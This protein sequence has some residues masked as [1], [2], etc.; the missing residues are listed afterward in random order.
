MVKVMPELPPQ[1]PEP[2]VI[3]DK[4]QLPAPAPVISEK[5]LYEHATVAAVRVRVVPKALDATMR[6]FPPEAPFIV[7]VP[8]QV[9]FPAR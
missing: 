6:R 8:V 9:K 1:S 3:A 7:R 4:F 5:S 2:P